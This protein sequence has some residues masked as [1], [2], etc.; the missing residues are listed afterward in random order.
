M[1]ATHSEHTGQRVWSKSCPAQ[2]GEC[3]EHIR[4][5]SRLKIAEHPTAEQTVWVV[6][7]RE[8]RLLPGA[9]GVTVA[10]ESL[11]PG[12]L[13]ADEDVATGG[14][15]IAD[16]EEV[17]AKQESIPEVRGTTK[18][19]S[20]GGGSEVGEETETSPLPPTTEEEKELEV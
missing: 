4:C 14:G 2:Q 3:E 11:D 5:P 8:R 1:L 16:G 9:E 10:A 7:F 13:T 15:N 20:I 18:S 19:R 17:T 12:T 6:S